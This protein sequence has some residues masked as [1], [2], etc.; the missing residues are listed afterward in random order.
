MVD[1]ADVEKLAEE[2]RAAGEVW[3]RDDLLLKLNRMIDMARQS[4]ENR[5]VYEASQTKPV[6]RGEPSE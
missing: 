1:V 4:A 2:L 6:E 3:F 5:A